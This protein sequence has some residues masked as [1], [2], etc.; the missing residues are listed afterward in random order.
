MDPQGLTVRLYSEKDRP[1]ISEWYK[2][3]GTLLLDPEYL[4]SGFIVSKN[5]IDI[6]V[7][8]LIETNTKLALYEYMQTNPN[9]SVYLRSRAVKHL[10]EF[11]VTTAKSMGYG[12]LMGMTPVDKKSLLKMYGRMGAYETPED[13]KLVVRRLS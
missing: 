8:F 1:E 9:A 5:G 11:M 2:K 10:T 12:S 7:G 6:A 13:Y 3:A 4:P